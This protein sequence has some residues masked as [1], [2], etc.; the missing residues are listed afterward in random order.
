MKVIMKKIAIRNDLFGFLKIQIKQ[1]GRIFSVSSIFSSYDFHDASSV[2]SHTTCLWHLKMHQMQFHIPLLRSS[3]FKKILSQTTTKE[4][5][6]SRRRWFLSIFR[7]ID[8][9]DPVK[10]LV[11]NNVIS[12]LIGLLTCQ[13]KMLIVVRLSEVI[14]PGSTYLGQGHGH[15]RDIEPSCEQ[16]ISR[17]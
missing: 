4:G 1:N 17:S 11:R 8:T 6:A 13:T 15:G 7:K 2:G 5:I 14:R 9:T 10:S 16:F 3:E 12:L